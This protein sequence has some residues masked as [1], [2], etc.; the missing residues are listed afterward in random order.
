[1][2]FGGGHD[3]FTKVCQLQFFTENPAAGICNP[4]CVSHLKVR[5]Q[6]RTSCA[7]ANVNLRVAT[8]V[9][10]GTAKLKRPRVDLAQIQG[11]QETGA[12]FDIKGDF[13]RCPLQSADVSYCGARVQLPKRR[14]HRSGCHLTQGD[15]ALGIVNREANFQTT[16][17][18]CILRTKPFQHKRRGK[19]DLPF[20]SIVL[21]LQN[22]ADTTLGIKKGTVH[23][24]GLNGYVL[25]REIPVRGSLDAPDGNGANFVQACVKSI[26]PQ[27]YLFKIQIGYVA[28]NFGGETS[29]NQVLESICNFRKLSQWMKPGGNTQVNPFCL[30][31]VGYRAF[32]LGLLA[33]S[34]VN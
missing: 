28:N 19:S 8:I 34:G 7:E 29:Q 20:K 24:T 27:T 31:K 30:K 17:R 25:K 33:I 16:E 26:C 1:M 6:S 18:L 12:T 11:L 2:N 32:N 13:R 10:Y 14:V 9:S 22:I 15:R 21:E 5:F 23:L 4:I 3:G